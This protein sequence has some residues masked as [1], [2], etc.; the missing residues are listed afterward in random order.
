MK[1]I[2]NFIDESVTAFN[3]ID[4]LKKELLKNKYEELDEKK[5]YKILKGHKYFITRNGTSVIAFNVGKK[6]I[7]PSLQIAAS[8]TDCP[9]FKIKPE[10]F[11]F[12][13]NYL[14]LNTEV[15]GGAIYYP[16]LDRALGIAGRVI[17]RNKEGLKTITYKSSEPF[18]VIPSVAIHQNRDVNKGIELNPQIDMLPLVSL[19]DGDLKA[20]LAKE[21]KTK[22]E[23]IK[24][25]DLYLYPMD[26][27]FNWGLK[28]EF[29]TSFHIDN[30]ECA[31]TTFKAFLNTFNDN[32]INVY[33]SFDNEEVGSLTRQGADSN[34]L[35]V[36]LQRLSKALKLDY[37]ALVSNG[38][39]LSCDNGHALHPNH[40]EKSDPVNRPLMNK[41]VVIKYNA[42]QS[43]TSDGLTSA[44]FT[45]LLDSKKIPYQ[46]FANRSDSKGGSTLGNLSNSHVSILSIDIG[47]AQLAMHSP[48]E[49]AGVKDIKYMI[50]AC[51]EFYN[52]HLSVKGDTY[53]LK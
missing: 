46:Y 8:H 7:N 16:W 33:C 14:K 43:Y 23:D 36:T 31:Y 39:L 15:Y 29:I 44:I 17:V 49:T 21:I 5:E 22:K 19:E 37:Y 4:N 48:M 24:G 35:E 45:N 40:P 28:K 38:M 51:K 20:F 42:N 3:A 47:L 41:G 13:K 26:K 30:L 25:F 2:M 34:F 10:A 1:E 53:I 11:I 27:A 9:T 18:C 12:D 6:L 32:N 50:D 52:A